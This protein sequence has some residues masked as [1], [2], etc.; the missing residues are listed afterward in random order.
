LRYR[1]GTQE[2][3]ILFINNIIAELLLKD[4]GHTD[5][6]FSAVNFHGFY[7]EGPIPNERTLTGGFTKRKSDFTTVN[8][9]K[10]PGFNNPY[11]MGRVLGSPIDLGTS[12]K[13]TVFAEGN[14]VFQIEAV[15]NEFGFKTNTI[16]VY[17]DGICKLQIQDVQKNA[18]T[19]ERIILGCGTATLKNIYILL[20]V[21]C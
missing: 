9:Y 15:D 12:R 16:E 17:K 1:T 18:D 4:S 14:K 5:V 19:F 13:Y 11:L 10:I 20:R 6:Y 21:E 2:E 3:K 8:H 7:R